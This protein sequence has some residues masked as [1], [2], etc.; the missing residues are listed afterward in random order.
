MASYIRPENPSAS[1]LNPAELADAK[2][3]MQSGR[4]LLG[5]TKERYIG[6]D[7]NRHI[8]TIAGSR[9]GKSA[10]SLMSNLLTWDG[11]TIVID[12]K[13]ELATNTALPRQKMGQ[14]VFILDPFGEVKGDG[15]LLN[16]RKSFNPLDELRRCD[17]DDVVDE[18]TA[19]A[20]SMITTEGGKVDHWALSAK[21]LIRG[22]ILYVLHKS[23]SSGSLNDVRALL[24]LPYDHDD[25]D[26]ETLSE[27]FEAMLKDEDAYDGVL[28]G[29]GGS[30][31][32]KPDN[33]RGSII[34]TAIEQTAFLDSTPLRD[35]LEKSGLPSMR[36]LKEKPATIFLVLP[37]S[38]MGTHFRWLRALLTQAM[39]ALEQEENATGRPVLF[40][41]EEFPTLGYM[42]LIEASAGLM[43]GYDVKLW[44][45]MQDLSQLK[46]HYPNSWETFLGNAGVIEAFSNADSTT[47]EYLSKR[48]GTSLSVQIQPDNP[49]IQ[50]Q[51][52]GAQG[53][54]ETIV[55]VPLMAP[56]EIAQA[57]SRDKQNKLVM[58]AGQKPFALR[59]IFWKDLQ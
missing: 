45:V 53:H 27:H 29:I 44:M 18:A 3:D 50:A 6:I 17:P 24:T 42:R 10:T 39:T 34:S 47:L 55:T 32:G 51:Q 33:E 35:H 14:D 4:I 59:R 41:L 9:A 58:I 15:A 36:V 20:D 48:L 22:L 30:L 1:W 16:L 31:L 8:A 43:A 49:S 25:K 54:R 2:Y 38:R 57:F 21:N 26:A 19:L 12:P 52:G 56:Y 7:D 40:I 28:S 46:A 13:G 23:P 5:R 37:A 11:S